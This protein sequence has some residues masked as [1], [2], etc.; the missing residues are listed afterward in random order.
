[1]LEISIV[2]WS[3]RFVTG[4]KLEI[5]VGVVSV[6][7]VVEVVYGIVEEEEEVEEVEEEFAV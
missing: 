6:V 4:F 1:L 5:E 2:S 7:D 3:T